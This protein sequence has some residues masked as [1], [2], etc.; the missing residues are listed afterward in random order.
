MTAHAETAFIAAQL[1]SLLAL[2]IIVL[3]VLLL[4]AQVLHKAGYSRW[5]SLVLLVP[6]VNL[7]MIWVFALSDWPALRGKSGN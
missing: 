2:L 6:A 3:I 7:V 5:W 4:P 1:V